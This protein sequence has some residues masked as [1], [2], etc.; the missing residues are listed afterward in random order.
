M[1][2]DTAK[3]IR[4]AK[5]WTIGKQIG[6][7]GF[8]RVFDA[9]GP[10]GSRAAL[11]L[12]PKAPGAARELLFV[13]L[14]GVERVVPI[15]DSG[16]WGKHWV[17]VMPRADRSLRDHLDKRGML[18]AEE[19]IAILSDVATGLSGL[20]GKIVHRDIKP[21]NILLLD[22]NWCLSDFGIARY[23]EAATSADTHKWAWSWPYN[24]PE[25]WRA[26][27]ASPASD[28][29]SLGVMAFEMLSGRLP[30]PG[31]D[32]RAQ[33][34][35]D[36]PPPLTGIPSL[37]ASLVTE[38]LFK[39]A[40]VRPTAP[41]LVARL[42]LILRPPSAAAGQLQEANEDQVRRMS[43]EVATR[44]AA[45]ASSERRQE[46][47]LSAGKVLEFIARRF[48]QSIIDNAPAAAWKVPR[49]AGDLPFSVA[50]GGA[51]LSL[52]SMEQSNPGVW[53]HWKP[54]FEVI[55]HAAIDL[56]IPRDYYDYEGRSHSLWFCDAQQTGIFHWYEVA[57]MCFALSRKRSRQNPFALAPGEHS[58]CALGPGMNQFDL[59]WSFCLV[60]PGNDGEFLERWMLWFAQAA[61]GQLSH[62]SSMPERSPQGSWRQN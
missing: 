32:F 7:G 58:G 54:A 55:G 52:S 51:S 42:A 48:R 1:K 35:T 15:I 53:G 3:T 12:I 11:K 44:S 14:V 9:A 43:G 45:Q 8:G 31:P 50:L 6:K 33:H 17:L 38:C 25:R 16:E 2:A 21:E 29:Y 18:S 19:S 34:L 10:D 56:K 28:V 24:P 30:F 37:L 20:G 39:A 22:G 41:S 57:F 5:T 47:A 60:E 4:L 61:K 46:I 40:E 13:N 59:A 36:E 23:A 26:E 27:R 62:P 49:G